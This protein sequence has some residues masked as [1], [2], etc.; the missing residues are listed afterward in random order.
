MRRTTY[1][2]VD[3]SSQ[4]LSCVIKLLCVLFFV[5]CVSAFCFQLFLIPQLAHQSEGNRKL[6]KE[7]WSYTMRTASTRHH[8]RLRRA[9][10]KSA[11]E[12][13]LRP[14]TMYVVQSFGP[15]A[16]RSPSKRI[17]HKFKWPFLNRLSCQCQC[18]SDFLYP[19]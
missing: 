4:D 9:H 16:L 13:R 18:T 12:D 8:P 10:Q 15:D 11:E 19:S 7:S 17:P 1:Y 6:E 5:I 3:V 2:H 14:A